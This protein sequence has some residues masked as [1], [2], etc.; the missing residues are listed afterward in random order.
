M[1]ST[2]TRELPERKRHGIQEMRNQTLERDEKNP[3]ENG[4][5]DPQTLTVQ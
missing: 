5:R 2:K 3:Q 1:R 4:P